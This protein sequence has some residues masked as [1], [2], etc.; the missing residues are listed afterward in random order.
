MGASASPVV[1]YYDLGAPER[2]ADFVQGVRAREAQVPEQPVGHQREFT[3]I[4]QTPPPSF[5]QSDQ[6]AAV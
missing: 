4:T 6:P 5:N 2:L 1:R 3:S